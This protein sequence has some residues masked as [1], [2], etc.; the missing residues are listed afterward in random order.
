MGGSTRRAAHRSPARSHSLSPE[1]HHDR[2]RRASP[3]RR[4]SPSGRG[5][6][7]RR[8]PDAEDRRWLA[9]LEAREAREASGVAATASQIA[10]QTTAALR[11][12]KQ[13]VDAVGLIAVFDSMDSNRTGRVSASQLAKALRRYMGVFVDDEAEARLM[14]THIIRAINQ[15]QGSTRSSLSLDV[16]CRLFEHQ[17]ARD[18]SRPPQQRAPSASRVVTGGSGSTPPSAVCFSQEQHASPPQYASPGSPPAATA[19]VRQHQ[20]YLDYLLRCQ[21]QGVEPA[22][23]VTAMAHEMM[24]ST[25]EAFLLAASVRSVEQELGIGNKG[26]YGIEMEGQ[27]G[28]GGGGGQGQLSVTEES[29]RVP[30][31]PSLTHPV[32]QTPSASH[33]PPAACSP[34]EPL[35]TPPPSMEEAALPDVVSQDRPG[36]HDHELSHEPLPAQS[37]LEA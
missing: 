8:L 29:R 30:L 10:A 12:L 15:R 33:P 7:A 13:H 1:G 26:Q 14:A 19:D 28:I 34:P 22:P 23:E 18:E 5:G 16:F 6:S 11:A 4:G 24:A 3:S 27:H 2:A 9:K 17:A 31:P 36:E 25:R 35:V 32:P 37:T 21:E 20:R